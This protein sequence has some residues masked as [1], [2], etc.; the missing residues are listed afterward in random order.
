MC[1][2]FLLLNL[3]GIGGE[4]ATGVMHLTGKSDFRTDMTL[5]YA[6][7]NPHQQG[8]SKITSHQTASISL[9]RHF[10]LYI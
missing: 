4:G 9:T 1:T 6:V 5:R 7:K 10:L 2:I 8:A 3:F